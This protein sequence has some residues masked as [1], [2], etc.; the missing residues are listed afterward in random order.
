ME[1]RVVV[2]E[3]MKFEVREYFLDFWGYFYEL[4]SKFKG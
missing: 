4:F 1:N 2:W 3:K